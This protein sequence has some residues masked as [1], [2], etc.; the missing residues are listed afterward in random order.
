M[1][2]DPKGPVDVL[3]TGAAGFIGQALVQ[4]L[5]EEGVSV[6]GV[7]VAAGEV[8]TLRL[9]VTDGSAVLELL[10]RL[11]PRRVVHAA[12][13]VDDRGEYARFQ[14]VNVA[15]TQN[16]LDAA[17]AVGVQ[18]FVQVSSIAALGLDPG[19][20]AGEGTPLCPDTGAPYFDTK[21]ASEELVRHAM[22]NGR[23]P[24]VIV[25]PGDVYGPRCKPWVERPLAMMRKKVPVLVGGGAGLMAHCWIG[26]LVDGLMLALDTPEIEGGIFQIHD[27]V[28]T[29]TYREYF[30][31]LAQAAG[32]QPPR[33]SLP[34]SAATALGRAFE[35]GGKLV[36]GPVPFTA[37]SV[38]YLCRTATYSIAASRDRLGY[39][40]RVDLDEGMERLARW[41][42]EHPPTR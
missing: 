18:R 4:R 17:A 20:G 22:A 25:R 8:P 14:E 1:P 30:T 19:V 5:L 32:L 15:G 26:N 31:R 41:L 13:L 10:R 36:G 12:A 11:E 16:M 42:R 23:L 2:V 33:T 40:P 3:V 34:A 27:G 9:D 35:L 7:D 6:Q 21:A 37:S 39:A 24:T 29:T 38:R 28:D